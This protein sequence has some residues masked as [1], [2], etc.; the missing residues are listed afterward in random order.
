MLLHQ[1]FFENAQRYKNQIAVITLTQRITYR[2]LCGFANYIAEKINTYTQKNPLVAIIMHKGWEQIAAAL[3]VLKAGYA[4]LPIEL[5]ESRERLKNLLDECEIQIVLTQKKFENLIAWP[6]NLK[7]IYVYEI[8]LPIFDQYEPH[9]EEKDFVQDPSDLAYVIYTS[10]STGLPKGVMISH[11]NAINTILDINERFNINQNDKVYSPTLLSFD[12]SV[13]D[14]FGTLAVGGSIILPEHNEANDMDWFLFFSEKATVINCVPSYLGTLIYYMENHPLKYNQEECQHLRLAF[15]SGDWIPVTLPDKAKQ[16]FQK[17]EL[18]SLGGATE[19]SI[20]SIMYPI[21]TIH[22]D[23]LSIPY[24]KPLKNQKVYVYDDNL[25]IVENNHIGHIYIGGMGVAMGYWKSPSLTSEKFIE[26]PITHERLYKT[27]D[28]GKYMPD[29]NIE[30]LGRSDQQVKINGYRIDVLAVENVIN[31]HPGIYSSAVIPAKIKERN[32]K[33]Y[34]YIV[35]NNLNGVLEKYPKKFIETQIITW[36]AISDNVSQEAGRYE[37]QF[38]TTGWISSYTRE[39]FPQTVMDEFVQNTVDRILNLNPR[40]TLEIGCGFG[41]LFFK[42]I[43]N[44]DSYVGIDFSE[45]TID[46]LKKNIADDI[47]KNYEFHVREANQLGSID[48]F[49]DTIIINSVIQYFPNIEYLIQTL[50]EALKKIEQNG[51]IFL[52]DVR[53]LQHVKYFY[54][55]LILKQHPDL[56][57]YPEIL[58]IAVNR[59]FNKEQELLI[60]PRFFYEFAQNHQE[61]SFVE[62]LLKQGSHLNEMNCFRYDVI[63]HIRKRV[64]WAEYDIFF[65]SKEI[66]IES[67]LQKDSQISKKIVNIPN[68]NIYN[69]LQEKDQNAIS[70]HYLYKLAGALGYQLRLSWSFQD[71]KAMNAFFYKPQNKQIIYADL[72]DEQAKTIKVPYFNEPIKVKYYKNLENQLKK[73]LQAHFPNYMIPEV[74]FF[75]DQMPLSRNGKIARNH[76]PNNIIIPAQTQYVAPK[77]KTELQLTKIWQKVLGIRKIGVTDDFFELG[78]DSIAAISIVYE[79]QSKLKFNIFNHIFIE[80]EA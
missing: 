13:Y 51:Q 38:N 42:L 29:G 28:L 48:K 58:K 2:T 61:I 23:W 74:F 19:G 11:Q 12:L 9:F 20:W 77:T 27:G 57:N 63:L 49:F 53:S 26:H 40:K 41:L 65:F 56:K 39:L 24:G 6:I 62:I 54:S 52:G 80:I 70:P 36:K 76:L 8:L 34:A 66:D 25:N 21:Q 37:T 47:Q 67:L 16:H 59:D 7:I 32:A 68:Q 5:T 30:F 15:L 50:E 31:R 69:F 79:M 71:D 75:I 22:S 18:I 72:E 1:P 44:L 17:L 46:V 43:N 10:G 35:I 78:G 73:K 14:I 64:E 33:L 4:Y 3:G 45:A 60:D 55:S